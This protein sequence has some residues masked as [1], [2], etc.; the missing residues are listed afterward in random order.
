MQ[1]IDSVPPKHTNKF[2][3]M[4]GEFHSRSSRVS[5]GVRLRELQW[6]TL[7]GG[8]CDSHQQ[9]YMQSVKQEELA[10][11]QRHQ[12]TLQQTQAEVE[13]KAGQN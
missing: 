2:G 1:N 7:T 9:Q 8:R 5:N 6:P 10:L 12:E 11:A 4:P 3:K 13:S